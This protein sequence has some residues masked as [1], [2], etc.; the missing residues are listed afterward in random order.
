M[1]F[2]K[3]VLCYWNTM[4]FIQQAI[5][6]TIISV[7]SLWVIWRLLKCGK[8]SCPCSCGNNCKCNIL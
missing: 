6:I 3:I 8:G 2:I 7:I 1:N 4:T 5:F